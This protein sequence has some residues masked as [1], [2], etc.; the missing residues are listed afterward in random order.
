MRLLFCIVIFGYEC[1]SLH[2]NVCHLYIVLHALPLY[3]LWMFYVS[4]IS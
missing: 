2:V 3:I 1:M 4:A